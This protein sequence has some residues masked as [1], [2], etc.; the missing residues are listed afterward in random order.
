MNDKK[1]AH[2]EN[3]VLNALI[4]G[5]IVGAVITSLVLKFL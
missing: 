5:F 4:I 1:P 2:Q 3:K